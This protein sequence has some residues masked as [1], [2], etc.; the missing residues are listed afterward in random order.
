MQKYIARRLLLYVPSLLAA[1]MVLFIVMRVLP[2]DVAL[3]ILGG[4]E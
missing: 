1:S 2:G 4:E 3:T